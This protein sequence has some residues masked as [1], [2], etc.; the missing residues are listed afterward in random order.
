MRARAQFLSKALR[1]PTPKEICDVPTFFSVTVLA[2]FRAG[3]FLQFLYPA[4]A[5]KDSGAP[6]PVLAPHTTAGC[7]VT[8]C[9]SCLHAAEGGETQ[10]ALTLGTLQQDM[11]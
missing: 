2:R 5:H 1:D 3:H 10:A 7:K 4:Q 9:M 11:Q 6:L 8:L